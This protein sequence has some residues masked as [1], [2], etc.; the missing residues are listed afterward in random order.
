[1][2]V[3]NQILTEPDPASSTLTGELL[4]LAEAKE[5]LMLQVTAWDS[6]VRTLVPAARR[7]CEGLCGHSLVAKTIF[8][9]APAFTQDSDGPDGQTA[10]L[11]RGGPVRSIVSVQY[12]DA[13]GAVQTLSSSV[14][15]VTPPEF[16]RPSWLTLANGQRWPTTRTSLTAVRVRYDVGPGAVS[17]A[18]AKTTGVTLATPGE[19]KQACKMLVKFWFDSRQGQASAAVDMVAGGG[20]ANVPTH[21]ES[22]VRGLLR[23]IYAGRVAG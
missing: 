18:I 12:E 19:A 22:S 15:E 20:A 16:G 6:L 17:D 10:L 21:L 9:T 2:S 1:M 14:Y 3:R 4:T 23:M 8:Q 11:L 5:H 13:T 7:Y